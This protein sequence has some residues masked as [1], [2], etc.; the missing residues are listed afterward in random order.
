MTFLLKIWYPQG[1]SVQYLLSTVLYQEDYVSL[2]NLTLLWASRQCSVDGAII[3]ERGAAG[4]METGLGN[5]RTG[6]KHVLVSLCS[7]EIVHVLK[8]DQT[9][10]VLVWSQKL[11]A[12]AIAWPNYVCYETPNYGERKRK[13]KIE[14]SQTEN[15]R[16]QRVF[17]Y[18]ICLQ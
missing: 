11:T 2:S 1:C 15:E 10:A 9:Q 7:P 6:K 5:L 18:C 17:T 14:M 13:G 4:E 12:R 16:S 8:W 3:D